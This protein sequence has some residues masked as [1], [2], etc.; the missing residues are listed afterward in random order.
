VF[1]DDGEDVNGEPVGLGHIRRDELDACPHEAGDA[2]VFC[3]PD[4]RAWQ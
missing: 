3:G 1:G 4:G 2:N